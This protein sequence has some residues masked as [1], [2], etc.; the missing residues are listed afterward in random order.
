[1]EKDKDIFTSIRQ[2][3]CRSIENY[4]TTKTRLAAQI[5]RLK[6]KQEKNTYPHW[7][8]GFLRPV[9]DEL[10]RLTP[11]I[12]W[13]D[14]KELPVFGLRCNCSVFGH[15]DHSGCTV[16][17]TF[18]CDTETQTLFY[19]IGRKKGR[20]AADSLGGLNGFDNITAPVT[21]MDDLVEFVRQQSAGTDGVKTRHE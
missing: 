5:E 7:T 18:T 14:R 9:L 11:E 4:Q 17:V 20:Y 1:M 6:K 19:D 15:H 8:D 21:C 2:E 16:G 10:A 12:E 13:E 3:Y